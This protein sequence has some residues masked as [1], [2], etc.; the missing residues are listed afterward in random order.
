MNKLKGFNKE[1]EHREREAWERMRLQT[2]HLINIQLPRDK[3]I[4]IGRLIRFPW[5]KER[6]E[7][8]PLTKEESEKMLSIFPKI[9]PEHLIP[10][11]N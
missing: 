7:L 6:P 1:V 8:R 3:N 9:L 4:S 10:K 2:W 11:N 5:D